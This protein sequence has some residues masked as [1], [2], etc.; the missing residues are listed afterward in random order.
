[1]D[2]KKCPRCGIAW[3]TEPD[4]CV[5]RMVEM[6]HVDPAVELERGICFHCAPPCWGNASSAWDEKAA[7]LDKLDHDWAEEKLEIE[8]ESSMSPHERRI[9]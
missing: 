2:V 8:K 4:G 9:R 6:V 1:M 3:T 5:S 7:V